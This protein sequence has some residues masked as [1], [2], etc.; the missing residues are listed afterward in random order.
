MAAAYSPRPGAPLG[1]ELPFEP[2][3]A[4][5]RDE[6]WARWLEH[7]PARFVP[8]ALAAF[9]RLRSV[10][11]DCG[12]RDEFNLRWGARR[13]VEALRAGGVEVAHEE[14]D[15]GHRGIDYRYG[16]SLAHL[17]PRLEQRIK[18]RSAPARP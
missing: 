17:G 2:G 12:T 16:R 7:D 11:V 10:Y 5:L 9:R 18:P 15:D 6:V 4:R 1:L 8:G 14:F 13:V 3:T